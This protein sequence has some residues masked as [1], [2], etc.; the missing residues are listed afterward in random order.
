MADLFNYIS[1]FSQEG[2]LAVLSLSLCLIYLSFKIIGCLL[3]SPLRY[4]P[5]PTSTKLTGAAI[6]LSTVSISNWR[7]LRTI[8]LNNKGMIK[9]LDFYK[10]ATLIGK[11]NIF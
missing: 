5:G 10:S 9:Y 7:H 4:V 6:T 11:D 3:F 8:Y 2:L 1:D